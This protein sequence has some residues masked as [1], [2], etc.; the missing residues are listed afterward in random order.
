MTKKQELIHNL[1]IKI[2]LMFSGLAFILYITL[3]TTG[4]LFKKGFTK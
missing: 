2:L 3:K 1:Y 4:K